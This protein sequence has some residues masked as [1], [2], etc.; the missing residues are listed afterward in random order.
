MFPAPPPSRLSLPSEVPLDQHRGEQDALPLEADTAATDTARRPPSQAAPTRRRPSRRPGGPDPAS[1]RHTREQMMT[2]LPAALLNDVRACAMLTALAHGDQERVQRLVG[3]ALQRIPDCDPDTSAAKATQALIDRAR[4]PFTTPGG[5][6]IRWPE[7]PPAHMQWAYEVEWQPTHI[8]PGLLEAYRQQAYKPHREGGSGPELVRQL[9]KRLGGLLHVTWANTTEPGHQLM[10]QDT[11][12]ELLTD[13]YQRST[14][15]PTEP[16]RPKPERLPRDT[17]LF[18]SQRQGRWEKAPPPST[19]PDGRR[20]RAATTITTDTCNPEVDIPATGCYSI[21]LG[22][23]SPAALLPT[24]SDTA[25]CYDPTGTCLGSLP[26][27]RLE[28]LRQRYAAASG[29]SDPSGASFATAV[30]ALLLRYRRTPGKT[31]TPCSPLDEACLPEDTACSL[32]AAMDSSTEYY[33]SPLNATRCTTRF[34]S[35]HAADATFGASHNAL[36]APF[37]GQGLAFPPPTAAG[38]LRALEWA[39]HSAR[40]A[41]RSGTLSETLLLLPHAP[42]S[43]AASYKTH[44]LVT[45]IATT[46]RE[47]A[48]FS[49]SLPLTAPS[50][51]EPDVEGTDDPTTWD[52]P[53]A[54]SQTTPSGPR[55][56]PV[57]D[58]Y[59]VSSTPYPAARITALQAALRQLDPATHLTPLAP[60]TVGPAYAWDGPLTGRDRYGWK[61]PRWLRNA[62]NPNRT[63]RR[64]TPALA[65]AAPPTHPPTRPTAMQTEDISLLTCCLSD[66]FPLRQRLRYDHGTCIYTDGSVVKIQTERGEKNLLGAAAYDAASKAVWYI[67]PNGGTKGCQTIMRCEL[68]GIHHGLQMRQGTPAEALPLTLFTDSLT[69]LYAIRRM[70]LRPDTLKLCKH[71]DLLDLIVAQLQRR[72]NAGWKTTLIKVKAHIGVEGNEK[73]DA[74]ATAVSKG[75][76]ADGY[77]GP[78]PLRDESADNDPRSKMWWP[79]TRAVPAAASGEPAKEPFPLADLGA[80]IDKALTPEIRSG[81]RPAGQYVQ[82]WREKAP[83]MDLK[84]ST[85]TLRRVGRPGAYRLARPCLLYSYGAIWNAKLAARFNIPLRGKRNK[86]QKRPRSAGAPDPASAPC[87]LCSAPDSGT[88]I[89]GGCTHRM[90]KA[91]Y[92]KRHNLGALCVAEHLARGAYGGS[93]MILDAT[94]HDAVPAFA[95]DQ[96]VPDWMLTRN[97]RP[98]NATERAAADKL[99]P[100][101]LLIPSIPLSATRAPGFRG[102]AFRE[103][104]KH[105][106]HIIEFGCC[107]DLRH[108]EKTAEKLEQ[109][110]EL[111]RRLREA[112]WSVQYN[113]KTILTLGFAGSILKTAA[114]LLNQLGCREGQANRC[115]S[116]LHGIAVS[117]AATILRSRRWLE[118]QTPLAPHGAAVPPTGGTGAYG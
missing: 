83:A 76:G 1:W 77:K 10:S 4:R 71:K 75:W 100:D 67:N 85:A 73:A 94:S 11:W 52:I 101:L 20:L 89:M 2:Q 106:V 56:H 96:R 23:Q 46:V 12:T 90:M 51:P 44:P 48:A 33:A 27:E 8:A 58:L 37:S 61:P 5:K 9:P 87:P 3:R 59:L 47:S 105:K 31:T 111:A 97:G 103:R 63:G 110:T 109:H 93:Y 117:Y 26:A 95:P 114:P 68:S 74:A 64:P 84:H 54:P 69:S 29:A 115:L 65:P 79:Q 30:A 50:T 16:Q 104:G 45:H 78:T 99:R 36:S 82:L 6:V 53:P 13:L 35:P 98:L 39:M 113:P 32:H 88:H 25:F 80:A 91:L 34:F 108:A 118:R 60:Q 81:F 55:R 38:G 102:P 70:L 28:A 66:A 57:W 86:G 22:R 62:I 21:Q 41:A 42:S 112:G 7:P 49:L 40:L 17:H 107:G 72:A 43:A 116:K 14:A 19:L 18:N 24:D 92:I 15:P